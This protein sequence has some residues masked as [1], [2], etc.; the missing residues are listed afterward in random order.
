MSASPAA[1]LRD[2]A[3]CLSAQVVPALGET[4][5]GKSAATVAGLLLMLAQDLEREAHD[6]EAWAERFDALLAEAAGQIAD[7]PQRLAQARA[8]PLAQ[9]MTHLLALFEEIHAVADARDPALAARCRD[10][11]AGWSAW[12][13]LEPVGP[14]PAPPR[15]D[16]GP[17][18]A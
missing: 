2:L 13:R 5:A 18:R 14:E 12:R 7:G 1:F 6:G 16:A 3:L 4:Y 11:L 9:R 17:A 10:L 15:P 8:L